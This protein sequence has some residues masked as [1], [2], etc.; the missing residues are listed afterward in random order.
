MV[1]TT[2]WATDP[3]VPERVWAVSAASALGHSRW[4]VNCAWLIGLLALGTWLG[5]GHRSPYFS[6]GRCVLGTTI[7]NVS[8]IVQAPQSEG[9]MAGITTRWRS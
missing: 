7:Y 5:G 1:G 4:F 6:C 2:Q 3:T 9:M 8:S